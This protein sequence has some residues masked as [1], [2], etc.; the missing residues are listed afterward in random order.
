VSH[1][2]SVVACGCLVLLGACTFTRKGSLTRLPTGP[3]IPVTIAVTETSATVEGTNPETGERFEGT[4]H[5]EESSASR[6]MLSPSP[7]VGGGSVTPGVAPAPVTGGRK[8]IVMV[9]LLKGD[10]DTVLKC[11]VQVQRTLQLPGSGTCRVVDSG[12]QKPA[13]SLRF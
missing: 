10:Q 12:E 3:E 7:A 4:F 1:R 11:W 9:G 2:W 8:T 13:Y 6:G 5:V